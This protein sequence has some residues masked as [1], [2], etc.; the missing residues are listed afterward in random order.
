LFSE[1]F[2]EAVTKIVE[3]AKL[4][5][6]VVH[7]KTSDGHLVEDVKIRE[8]VEVFL[9]QMKTGKKLQETI[10]ER[11]VEFLGLKK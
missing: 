6:G 8:D 11:A 9:L 2:R 10:M 4:V 1:K 5:V 7:W 3:V